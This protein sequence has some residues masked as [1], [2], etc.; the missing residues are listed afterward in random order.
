MLDDDDLIRKAEYLLEALIAKRGNGTRAEVVRNAL[1]RDYRTTQPGQISYA[2]ARLI[3]DLAGRVVVLTTNFDNVID[4]SLLEMDSTFPVVAIPLDEYSRTKDLLEDGKV[5]VVHVHGRL[6]RLN[7]ATDPDMGSLVLTE[8]DFLRH[9]NDVR[10]VVVD[11][12]KNS[13]TIF[14][15]LSLTDP[16][17]VGPLW[18]T[19]YDRQPAFVLAVPPTTPGAK[20]IEESRSYGIVK[21]QYLSTELGL[22]PVFLKS[23][24]QLSQLLFEFHI[25]RQD[26]DSYLDD[27]TPTSLAYGYR[28]ERLLTSCYEVL[29]Y[30]VREGVIGGNA[31]QDRLTELSKVADVKN[32]VAR[33]SG[34]NATTV[35]ELLKQFKASTKIK[36]ELARQR[37]EVGDI[38]SSE[39]AF[40]VLLWLRNFATD[41]VTRYSIRV[42]ASSEFPVGVDHV[43][44]FNDIQIRPDSSHTASRALANGR[45]LFWN[46]PGEATYGVWHGVLSV[47]VRLWEHFFEDVKVPTTVGAASLITTHYY[48]APHEKFPPGAH[49][50]L[51]SA[52]SPVEKVALGELLEQQVQRLFTDK[53]G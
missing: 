28:F 24:T 50:S 40:A 31:S 33:K 8:S 43:S 10:R 21:N 19:R 46:L 32:A 34:A 11:R 26:V 27:S 23:Y 37:H 48:R 7:T 38:H 53:P 12:L 41:G 39:E 52:L 49:L 5:P 2:L 44:G 51:L 4:A 15:G 6:G 36:N 13:T 47:P 29:G 14:L 17:M 25:S 18:D 22:N 35:A 20:S 9:G 42:V 1:Y 30:T 3:K 16:N 45:G